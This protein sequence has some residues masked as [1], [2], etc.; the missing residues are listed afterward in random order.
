MEMVTVKLTLSPYQIDSSEPPWLPTTQTTPSPP[1][2]LTS[3]LPPSQNLR[4]GA[5]KAF[6]AA[7]YSKLQHSS[8]ALHAVHSKL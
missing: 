8:P 6:S 3:R 1:H 2:R 4:D 5:A 7:S